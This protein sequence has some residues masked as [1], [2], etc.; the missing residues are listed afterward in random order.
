MFTE[1]QNMKGTYYTHLY[2]KIDNDKI[3]E[4]LKEELYSYRR[5]VMNQENKIKL[6]Q[7]EIATQMV[8]TKMLTEDQEYLHN[9]VIYLTNT[10]T[11]NL[12]FQT[13]YNKRKVNQ[14]DIRLTQHNNKCDISSKKNI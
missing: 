2:K 3:L 9:Q 13:I 11:Y 8:I 5:I 12:P 6:L 14:T 1:Y 10:D 7:D 4:E